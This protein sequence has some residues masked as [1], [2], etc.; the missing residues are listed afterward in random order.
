MEVKTTL[1]IYGSLGPGESNYHIISHINGIWCKAFINGKI[2]DNGWENRTGY[3]V[4]Q[5]VPESEATTVEVLA[6]VSEELDDHW[7]LI[8]EFEGTEL[9]KRTTISCELEGGQIV[10]AFIYESTKKIAKHS[11]PAQLKGG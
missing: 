10:D 6:F 7:T 5:R 2:I 9:Y 4:F 3:P 11:T 8:D 1:I